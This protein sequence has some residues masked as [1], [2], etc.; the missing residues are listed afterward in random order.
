MIRVDISKAEAIAAVP[1][2]TDGERFAVRQKLLAHPRSEWVGLPSVYGAEYVA[3]LETAAARLRAQCGAVVIVGAGGSSLGA[4]TLIDALAEDG[5]PEAYYCGDNLSGAYLEKLLVRLRGKDFGVVVSSKSGGTLE[6]LAALRVLY[7]ELRARYGAS[8]PARVL[9]VTGD[10]PSA[11]KRFADEYSCETFDIPANVGG[12]YSALTPAGLLPAAVFGVNIAEVLRGAASEAEPELSEAAFRYAE[13]RNALYK[14]GFGTEIFASFEPCAERLGAWWRQL[15]GESE[16]KDGQGIFP[17]T[18]A[19]TGDLHSMGQYIQD[20]R[21][22]LFETVLRFSDARSAL[23]VPASEFDDGL[24]PVALR[25]FAELNALA[26]EAVLDAHAAGG[27]PVIRI[28]AAEPDGRGF[29]AAVYFFE[30]ACAYSC[31]SRGI[32]PFDQPG[33]EAYKIR[34]KQRLDI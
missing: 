21:R 17:A 29:G 28:T 5:A 8:A 22:D 31:L 23:R 34:I 13:A 33:V 4:R 12:R 9:C 26:E 3:R 25:R 32:D 27:V 30:L 19:F 1:R 14:A 18:A 11:L 20:G 15:F 6:T 2:M 24:S 7:A 10:E 16:G